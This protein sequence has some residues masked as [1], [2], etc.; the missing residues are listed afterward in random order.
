MTCFSASVA[1]AGQWRAI[2]AVRNG[3][4]DLAS[5]VTHRVQL[6]DFPEAAASFASREDGFLKM[7]I[8]P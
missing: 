6:E 1:K 4:I 5:V 2:Q 8:R 3:V 7:V